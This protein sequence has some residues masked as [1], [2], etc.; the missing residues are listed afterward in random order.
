MKNPE[1]FVRQ[2]RDKRLITEDIYKKIVRAKDPEPELY[3][4]L[5]W[6]QT[7]KKLFIYR[8]WSCVF[9]KH[10][11]D[12]YPT[13]RELQTKLYK[14]A[15]HNVNS[16]LGGQNVV[17][18]VVEVP[19]DQPGSSSD[20]TQPNEQARSSLSVPRTD[21]NLCL[22]T[23]GEVQ[24]QMDANKLKNESYSGKSKCILYGGMWL[25]SIEFKRVGGKETY[26]NWKRSIRYKNE[27]LS[28]Y[29]VKNGRLYKKPKRRKRRTL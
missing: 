6:I 13:V 29:T 16:Q 12:K 27:P 22:V 7:T 11:I 14:K 2:L 3:K 28:R 15:G 4:A 23:C 8:F 5:E 20:I 24:G 19:D 1:T 17:R 10:I 21:Q 26:K 18:P 25:S 9:E